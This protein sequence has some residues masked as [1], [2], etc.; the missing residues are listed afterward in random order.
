MAKTQST[1]PR[2]VAADELSR[3]AAERERL[4]PSLRKQVE[5]AE[6]EWCDAKKLL[7]DAV[8][9]M[10]DA[11]RSLSRSQVS[12][13][14]RE[15]TAR[16]VLVATASP[17]I[18]EFIDEVQFWVSTRRNEFFGATSYGMQRWQLTIQRCCDEARALQCNPS[19]DGKVDEMI[20]RWRQEIEAAEARIAERPI[21]P[22]TKRPAEPVSVGDEL[23]EAVKT[24]TPVQRTKS[25]FG[26]RY[27]EL[28]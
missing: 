19:D 13:S 10:N 12:L 18:A 3:V 16:A 15:S 4:L 24:A 11:R 6:R 17:K 28:D 25:K 1:D 20:A 21:D 23:S 8:R 5:A 9:T 7:E 27:Q 2:H 14:Q 22:K 26:T